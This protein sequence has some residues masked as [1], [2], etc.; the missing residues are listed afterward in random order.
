MLVTRTPNQVYQ[1]IVNGIPIIPNC[2]NRL[3]IGTKE[4]DEPYTYLLI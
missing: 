4:A 2:V 1:A 3:D